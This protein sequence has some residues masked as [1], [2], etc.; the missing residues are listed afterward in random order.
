MSTRKP[1]TTQLPGGVSHPMPPPLLAAVAGRFRALSEPVRL[2]LLETLCEG[3]AS[4]GDLAARCGQSHA[5][6]SKHLQ[7]LSQ[8]GFV[9]RQSLG[10]KAVYALADETTQRLCGLICEHVVRGAQAGLADLTA[11][12]RRR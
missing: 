2:R 9:T 7:I 8:S 5:N 6:T 12:T 3:Q 4:V 1:D 11:R 10:T